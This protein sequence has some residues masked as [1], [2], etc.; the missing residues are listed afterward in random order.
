[1][2]NVNII[3]ND[4]EIIKEVSVKGH[5]LFDKKGKDVV[6]AGVSALIQSVYL[7]IIALYKKSEREKDLIYKEENFGIIIKDYPFDIIGELKGITLVLITGLIEIEKKYNK[8]LKIDIKR[9]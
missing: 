9:S 3:I 1:M 5:S 7:A 4:N 6:C 2:I 8:Q